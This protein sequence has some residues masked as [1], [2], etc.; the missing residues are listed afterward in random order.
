MTT[1]KDRYWPT[2]PGGAHVADAAFAGSCVGFFPHLTRYLNHAE[3][4]SDEDTDPELCRLAEQIVSIRFE[5][6][7]IIIQKGDNTEPSNIVVKER[8]RAAAG[9]GYET[10]GSEYKSK[11]PRL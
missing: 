8:E 4:W 3:F 10:H 7:L 2:V 1:Y 6:N 5:H 9:R 11:E